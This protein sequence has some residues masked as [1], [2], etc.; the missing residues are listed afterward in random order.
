[1]EVWINPACSKCR[2]AT[3]QLDAA[4]ASYTV[5]RYLESPPT[6]DELEQVLERLG[7]EPWQLARMNESVVTEIGLDVLPRAA[8]FRSQ[9]IAAMTTH[10]ALIQRPILIPDEGAAVIGRT[11]EAMEQALGHPPRV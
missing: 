5:R 9:W 11:P 10:P 6:A 8:E 2:A 7:L 1:M 4:G 3:A